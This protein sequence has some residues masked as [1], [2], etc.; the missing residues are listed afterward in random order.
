VRR[1]GFEAE[2]TV[3]DDGK[4]G[5]VNGGSDHGTQYIRSGAAGKGLDHL[6]PVY[7]DKSKSVDQTT[8]TG[9][10]ARLNFLGPEGPHARF[11][12]AP[13][14]RRLALLLILGASFSA[15]AEDKVQRKVAALLEKGR[16]RW[17]ASCPVAPLDGL[18]LEEV[19][20]PAPAGLRPHC[21]P[22]G[23]KVLRPVR[24]EA[25][26]ALEARRLLHQA[27]SLLYL[28]RAHPEKEAQETVVGVLFHNAEVRFDE[29][30]GTRLPSLDATPWSHSRQHAVLRTFARFL[31]QKSKQLL[32][33]RRLYEQVSA[34]EGPAS[35]RIAACTRIGQLYHAF[36]DAL[37]TA[38]I[39]RPPIPR[40][41]VDERERGDFVNACVDATC[42]TLVDKAVPL[43]RQ[44][45][46]AYRS[47]LAKARA[48][49]PEDPWSRL[50]ASELERLRTQGIYSGKRVDN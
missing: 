20:P 4:C 47:C 5:N 40:A 10:Q 50:C 34:L 16:A 33:A 2:G 9:I 12:R 31:D 28:L 43:E 48:M 11:P 14:A 26:A 22:A 41:M 36:A 39:P 44:A 1:I 17:S 23:K 15:R 46:E 3:R 18:C 8:I 19:S 32:A 38:P 25:K 45:G 7:K 29:F 35:T 13:T 37:V 27:L 6:D 49:A 42:D 21:G 30:L 24:R